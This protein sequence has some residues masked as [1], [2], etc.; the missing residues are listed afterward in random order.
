MPVPLAGRGV[1][2]RRLTLLHRHAPQI[3]YVRVYQNPDNVSTTCNP[4]DHPTEQY[5][6]W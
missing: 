6:A 1:C 2:A 5:I 3:D 4:A